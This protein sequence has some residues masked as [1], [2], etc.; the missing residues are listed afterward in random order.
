MSIRGEGVSAGRELNL[1]AKG[2]QEAALTRTKTFPLEAKTR[3][4]HSRLFSFRAGDL[5]VITSLMD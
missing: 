4:R 1:H 3:V 2:T 5:F